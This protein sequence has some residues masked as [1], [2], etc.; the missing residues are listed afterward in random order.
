MRLKIGLFAAVA[1]LGAAGAAAAAPGV[2]IRDAVA[3]VVVIP[4]D[5]ADVKVEMLTTN[6]ALP[7]EVRQ[8]GGTTV[9]DGRLGHRIGDCHTRG[10]HPSTYI[11]GVGRVDYKDMPQVIIHA[12]KAVMIE[13]SG[14]VFGS[15][16]RSGSLDLADSGCDAWTVADVT[17]DATLRESGAGAV[18]MGRADRLDVRLSGAASIHATDVKSLDATLSGVGGV[19]VNSLAGPMQAHVSGVGNV[20]VLDGRATT[21]RASVSG[22]GGVQFGGQADSLDAQI[23]GLGGI[24][25]KSVT[26][27]VNK[28]VSGAG[29]VTIG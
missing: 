28:S 8:S 5:R 6:R 11:R 17:G 27:Q 25:V 19:T 15:I 3:R 2:E 26:G 24:R 23:S 16:G 4:E 21:V 29:H 10:D 9:I 1:A 18:R 7:L 14:A 22:M 20:K 13:A 12:P